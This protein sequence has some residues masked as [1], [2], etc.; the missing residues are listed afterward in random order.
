MP[1]APTSPLPGASTGPRNDG[2]ARRPR[3]ARYRNATVGRA[4]SPREEH[5]ERREAVRAL[6]AV[7]EVDREADVAGPQR[8]APPAVLRE[9]GLGLEN[10]VHR[11]APRALEPR[12]VAEPAE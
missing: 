3:C 1:L 8:I 9:V 10:P 6:D 2:A 4:R 12:R 5:I 7:P 11:E